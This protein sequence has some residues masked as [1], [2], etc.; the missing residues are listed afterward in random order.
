MAQ[1]FQWLKL[2]N[3]SRFPMAHDFQWLKAFN[4]YNLA[5]CLTCRLDTSP[6]T[7]PF[8]IEDRSAR[9][10]H[11]TDEA[12]VGHDTAVQVNLCMAVST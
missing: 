12:F 6:R 4:A 7:N 9:S 8:R 2:S 1:D 3:G 11:L 10:S 5:H